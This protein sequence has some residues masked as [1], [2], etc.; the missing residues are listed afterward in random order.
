MTV[1]REELKQFLTTHGVSAGDASAVLAELEAYFQQAEAGRFVFDPKV[2]REEA[3]RAISLAIGK[4]VG[5]VLLVSAASASGSLEDLT[6]QRKQEDIFS[7]TLRLYD[8]LSDRLG[9]DLWGCLWGDLWYILGESLEDSLVQSGLGDTSQDSLW[10]TIFYYVGSVLV[11]EKEEA[12]KLVPLIR[13]QSR[14]PVF[15]KMPG[16]AD[17]WVVFTA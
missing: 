11:G 8:F 17:T 13:L 12:A 4:P 1:S 16:M 10:F 9:D 3:K 15:G 14:N 6:S 5:E 2:D 7:H